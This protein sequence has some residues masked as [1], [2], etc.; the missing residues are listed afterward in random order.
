MDKFPN[1]LALRQRAAAR[2]FATWTALRKKRGLTAKPAF[3]KRTKEELEEYLAIDHG[4]SDLG[5][6]LGTPEDVIFSNN[7]TAALVQEAILG[8]YFASGWQPS[9]QPGATATAS[10]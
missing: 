2:R 10:L 9:I 4:E 3:A 5:Y 1:A 7:A 8:P 6:N